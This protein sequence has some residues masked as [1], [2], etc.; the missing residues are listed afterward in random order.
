MSFGS[1]LVKTYRIFAIFQ[2]AVAQ[3]KKIVSDVLK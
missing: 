1:L 2:K 3:F